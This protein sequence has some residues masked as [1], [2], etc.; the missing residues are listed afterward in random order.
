MNAFQCTRAALRNTAAALLMLTPAAAWAQNE[1]YPNRTVTVIV[2]YASISSGT[3]PVIRMLLAALSEKFGQ[4]FIIETRGGANGAIGMNA[5]AKAKPD[6]YT[7][8]FTNLSPTT[9]LPF[10]QKDVPYDTAKEFAPIFM[11][12]RG[13]SFILAG[14]SVKLPDLGQILRFAKE[15]PGK[16]TYAAVGAAQRLN[17][18]K[19]ESATGARFLVVP[20]KG[21]GEAGA[22]LLGG[23]V[24]I[25]VDTGDPARLSKGGA[26][27][28]LA[29]NNPV[30]T[31][32]SPHIP[33]T[34]EWAPGFESRAWH[35]ILGP[36]GI[37]RDRIELLHRELTA[38]VK[39]PRT[40][41]TMLRLGLEPA[42]ASIEDF[43]AVIRKE[44]QDHAQIV[45]QFNI[46]PN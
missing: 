26:L 17:I 25:A 3:E 15:N 24:D 10:V 21:T 4:Q 12:G 11:I 36:T 40:R 33:V 45:K 23:H 7:L 13:E 28:V 46:I 35:G 6:G 37:P 16:L 30:R 1:V 31:K 29:S 5:V 38:V 18:A 34:A 19:L 22:A 43:A 32:H 39:Q 20:Y 27:R 2:P 44:L 8:V 41:E 42:D 14:P 9:V